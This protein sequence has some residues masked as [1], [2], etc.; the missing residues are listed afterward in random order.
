M[1]SRNVF[2]I[3]VMSRFAFGLTS[4]RSAVQWLSDLERTLQAIH[5]HGSE[6]AHSREKNPRH[7][8]TCDLLHKFSCWGV[9]RVHK[10]KAANSGYVAL[11]AHT[12][13]M[14]QAS[15]IKNARSHCSILDHIAGQVLNLPS[16]ADT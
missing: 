6:S 14:G 11:K 5:L 2:A 1:G 16:R 12:S 9:P 13:L 10:K 4:L 7:K 8:P 15:H 3:G